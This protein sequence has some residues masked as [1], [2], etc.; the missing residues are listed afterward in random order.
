M[1]KY[2]EE[3]LRSRAAEI[4]VEKTDSSVVLDPE[5]ERIVPRF[6]SSELKFGVVL[7]K[8][9]FC[10]VSEVKQVNLSGDPSLNQNKPSSSSA[11][12]GDLIQDREY[13]SKNYRRK[14]KDARYAI[15]TL[16]KDIA[17][18]PERYVAGIIDLAIESK[19]LAVIRHPNIV[20][21]RGISSLS[22]Y[23]NGFFVVLDRLYDTLTER[24]KAWKNKKAN[25]TGF[26]KVRDLRGA[27]KKELWIDRLIVGYD[28][29]SALK[30]LHD[31]KIVYRDLKPD[32]VGF[33]CRGDVKV[34][35]FGL[36]KEL[37]ESD[38][39]N[40]DT[41]K[42][43]GNTGSLRYMAPEVALEQPYNHKVDL[44]SFGVLL[45]QIC[46]L[47]TPFTS[48][49]VDMHRELVVMG[50]ERPPIVSSWSEPLKKLMSRC[51]STDISTR[52]DCATVMGILRDEFNPFLGA[53]EASALDVS[54][55]TAR[56]A[57]EG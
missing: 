39:Y 54:N 44:F 29:C 11:L 13:I 6:H 25:L 49:T 24:I 7:G 16:S 55:R 47:K 2:T 42:L 5:A 37:S 53:G 36:A 12:N 26:A 38:R 20:K 46:S 15:K 35:D 1:P 48:Y 45:W 40:R 3:Y 21:M 17:G 31:S 10:T 41:Y 4:V 23:E 18:N 56:S 30:Y 34:F 8:G 19:F 22:P 28:I 50:G 9:G 27:K 52:P 14:G 57:M 33:D 43:S 51:W 32:N